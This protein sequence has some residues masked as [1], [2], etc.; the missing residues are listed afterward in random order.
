MF[1]RDAFGGEVPLSCP[2]PPLDLLTAAAVLRQAG[3][4]VE[5]LAANVHGWS[6]EA[7]ASHLVRCPPERILIP[8]AWGSITDDL[9]LCTLLRRA[10]PNTQLLLSGPNVTA[11]PELALSGGDVDLVILGEPEEAL[12]RLAGGE[13][14]DRIPNLAYANPNGTGTVV[15]TERRLPPDYANYP[16]PAWDLIDLERYTIPFCRRLPATTMATARGCDHTCTFCPSQIWHQRTVRPRALHGVLE[17][18]ELLTGKYGVR[19]IVLRDDT[20]TFDRD[21]VSA[22]CRELRRRDLDLTW[23]CFATVDAVDLDLC[24]EM[25]VSG[26]SQICYGFESGVDAILAQTGKRTTVEQGRLAA[27]WTHRAGMEVAGTFIVG[28]EGETSNTLQQSLDFATTLGLDYIQINPAAPLPGTGFGKRHARSGRE[29]ASG[30]FRWSGNQTIETESMDAIEIDR[31]VRRFYGGFYLRPKYIAGR[32]TSRRGLR[33]LW[34]H[35]VL[36][37]RMA[38]YLAEPYMPLGRRA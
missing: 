35:A 17:E 37:G 11:R 27:E 32:V 26:C 24:R 5:L 21:R 22:F 29:G 36:G 38:L 1:L 18:I 28:L 15:K 30:R 12:L 14:P 9:R 23:R 16:I 10:L 3:H 31:A 6:H 13:A 4:P 19:E 33:S 2:Y 25:A 20:F 7:V 8:S 34:S